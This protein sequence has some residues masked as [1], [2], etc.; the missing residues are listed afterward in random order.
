MTQLFYCL[1]CGKGHRAGTKIK[2]EHDKLHEKHVK[3]DW[4]SKHQNK[5]N[6]WKEDEVKSSF[7]HTIYYSFIHIF[8]TQLPTQSYTGF[9][10][11]SAKDRY[12]YHANVVTLCQTT[13]AVS[14]CVKN[15]LNSHF[16]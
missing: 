3:E 8:P 10:T 14:R 5:K 16:D 13:K 2:K 11:R 1:H 6:T 15:Y 4:Y 7:Q 9:V 12:I